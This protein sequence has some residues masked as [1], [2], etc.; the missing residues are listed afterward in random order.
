[1]EL[2]HTIILHDQVWVDKSEVYRKLYYIYF[3]LKK[4]DNI[5]IYQPVQFII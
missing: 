5:Y 1:M 4:D 3:R 2:H